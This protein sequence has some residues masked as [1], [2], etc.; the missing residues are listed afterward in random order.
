M[1]KMLELTTMGQ[2]DQIL[3]ADSRPTFIFKHSTAC[4]IS[5][6]AYEQYKKFV[7]GCRGEI[8]D[9]AAIMIREHREISNALA[10][11]AGVKH[12]SPQGILIVQGKAVWDDSHMELT[13]EKFKQVVMMYENGHFKD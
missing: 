1:A 2:L 6:R 3:S 10:E 4:P 13:E 12:E 8:F 5:M 7:E 9:F 11:K